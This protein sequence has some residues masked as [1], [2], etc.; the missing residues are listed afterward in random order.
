MDIGF[1]KS[2]WD[3]HLTVYVVHCLPVC[4]EAFHKD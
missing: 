1:S 2:K 4:Q 3:A